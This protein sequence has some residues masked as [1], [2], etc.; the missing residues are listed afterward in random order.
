MS[1]Q[2]SIDITL[3]QVYHP[4]ELIHIYLKNGWSH[5]DHGAITYLPYQDKGM[6]NWTSSKF[7][8]EVFFTA[9]G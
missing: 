7:W 8:D 4:I 1:V 3:H 9:L 2:S 6:F 5:N